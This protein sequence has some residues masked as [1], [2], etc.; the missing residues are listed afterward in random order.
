MGEM[1]LGFVTRLSS[2]L[3][4]LSYHDIASCFCRWANNQTAFFYA[5]TQQAARLTHSLCRGRLI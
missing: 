1:P 5:G 3:F 2:L 4:G